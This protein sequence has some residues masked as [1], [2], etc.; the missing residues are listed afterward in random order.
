VAERTEQATPRRRHEARKRGETPRSSELAGAAA[1]LGALLCMRLCW[2][3]VLDAASRIARWGLGDCARWPLE[4]ESVSALAATSLA[5]AAQLAGPAAL[6]ACAAP[7][8][9]NLAQ[10]GFLVS[11]QPLAMNWRRLS[12][13]QGMRRMCSMRG[14]FSVARSLLKVAAVSAVTYAFICSRWTE[15]LQLGHGSALSAGAGLG[16]LIWGLLIQVA[17]VLAVAAAADYAFE[18]RDFEKNLRMTRQEAREEHRRA[19]GDPLIRSRIRERQRATARHRM[20]EAV[21]K[22][23]VVVV[24]PTEIAVALRYD[25]AKTPAPVVVAK[26]R[27]LMAQRIREQAEKHSV[28]IHRHTDLAR[29]LYRSVPIG[30]QIPPELY[31]VVAEILAFVYRTTGRRAV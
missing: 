12:I 30:R 29:S 31:Q 19:E 20:I 11:A 3:S 9:A 13:A 10:S 26:G 2:S 23:S 28:P 8:V 17:L 24:N 15:M 18:R 6:G 25:V 4:V 1:L 22:A 5:F 16:H 27:H 14:F 7:L 21:K